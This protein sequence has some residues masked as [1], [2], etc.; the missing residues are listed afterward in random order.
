MRAL[1]SENQL[2]EVYKQ[3]NKIDSKIADKNSEL[4]WISLCADGID[5]FCTFG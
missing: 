4:P 1:P 2:Q 5:E 3:S